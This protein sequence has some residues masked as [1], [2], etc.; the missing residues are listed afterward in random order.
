MKA[1]ELEWTQRVPPLPRGE[2]LA[3]TCLGSESSLLSGQ[4]RAD[5]SFLWRRKLRPFLFRS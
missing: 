5:A 4:P 1:N 3:Q 2:Y